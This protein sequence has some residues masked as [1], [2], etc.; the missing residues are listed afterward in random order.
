MADAG[1]LLKNVN[2][3]LDEPTKKSLKNSIA[4]VEQTLTHFKELSI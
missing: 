3:I 2:A 4:E 1:L